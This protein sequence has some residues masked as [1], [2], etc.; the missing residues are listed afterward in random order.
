MP[1][2]PDETAASSAKQVL[3]VSGRMY[4]DLAERRQRLDMESDIAI[5]RVEQ[6]HPLPVDEI[7]AELSKYTNAKVS[8]VQDEPANQGPWPFMLQY[9]LP[10]LDRHVELVSRSASASPSAGNKP[11]HDDEQETLLQDVFGA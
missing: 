2:V 7:Q 6:L 4:Y 9:L 8:W 10:E 5:V 1:V 11:R 3:L